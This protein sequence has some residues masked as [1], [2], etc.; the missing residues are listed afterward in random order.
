MI[1]GR[2]G[3][4]GAL[5]GVTERTMYGRGTIAASS[6]MPSGRMASDQTGSLRTVIACARASASSG[7][8]WP[9]I[10]TRAVIRM[11][12]KSSRKEALRRYHSS[13]ASFSL[14]VSSVPPLTCAQPVM[15]RGRISWSLIIQRKNSGSPR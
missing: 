13:S 5:G 9:Q 11:M 15:P 6:A 12:R 3:Q 10:I 8:C 4:S 2:G 14:G 7:R 1:S